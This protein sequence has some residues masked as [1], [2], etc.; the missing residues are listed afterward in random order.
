MNDEYYD[1]EKFE[2]F[3]YHV[4]RLD[5]KDVQKVSQRNKG[6]G[7]VDLIITIPN[8]DGTQK[9]IGI[10]A[11][12][13]KN[14][15][16]AQP[17]NQLTS[18]K[19]RHGLTD[20]W[21]ITTSDL[22]SDAQQIAEIEKIKILRKED[23]IGLINNVKEIHANKIKEKGRSDIEFLQPKKKEA[24]VAN[25]EITNA[26]ANLI[27][28]ELIRE[29]KEL[30]KKLSKKYNLYPVYQVFNNDMLN[31]IILKKPK[32]LD[33]LLEVKGFGQKKVDLFG[34]EIIEFVK[35]TLIENS[36]KENEKKLYE[37]L[38]LERTKIAKYNHML[39]EEVYSDKVA[40]E[41]VKIKPE[42][43]ELLAK[44]NGFDEKNIE[45]FGDYLIRVINKVNIWE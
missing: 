13:W 17:M 37:T 30:R 10:Q 31:N 14:R 40:K 35:K 18:A 38:L 34:I 41:L 4:F 2:W 5:N 33:E 39:E 36:L 28:G 3:L 15:V 21:L 19:N 27:D 7:G 16:G 8:P 24:K 25:K 44:V 43:K 45:I 6:D 12:Y 29:L 42:K 23:V 11:K 32:N 1:Y 22:T 26:N 9:R 20:L